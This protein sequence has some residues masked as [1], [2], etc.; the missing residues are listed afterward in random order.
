MFTTL[1]SLITLYKDEY[2][3]NYRRTHL[4][5]FARRQK[6]YREKIVTPITEYIKKYNKQQRLNHNPIGSNIKLKRY[7]LLE[8]LG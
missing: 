7:K 5:D 4:E 2:A 8:I 3:H 1:L 6:K